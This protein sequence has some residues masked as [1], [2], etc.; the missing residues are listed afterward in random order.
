MLSSCDRSERNPE[1]KTNAAKPTKIK[2]KLE[3]PP[4]PKPTAGPTKPPPKG[5]GP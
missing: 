4:N 3:K 5:D 1:T 2:E